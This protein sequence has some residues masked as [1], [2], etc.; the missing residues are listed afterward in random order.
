MPRPD[1]Q[2]DVA[3]QRLTDL[4]FGRA[5]WVPD[6]TGI[7]PAPPLPADV[8]APPPRR[9]DLA[10][11]LRELDLTSSRGALL[12]LA[13]FCA[14]LLLVTAWALMRPHG[15]PAQAAAA[16][17]PVAALPAPT[18][19]GIVVDVAGRVRRPG[20]VTLPAG[21]RVSDAVRAAGG[22]LRPRDLALVN[23]AARVSDGQLLVV[24][25]TDPAAAADGSAGPSA[26]VSLNTATVDQLDGLPGIGPVLAQRIV[27]WRTQHGGFRS[28]RDLDQVS[29][30]GDSIYAELE[31]LVTV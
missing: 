19:S 13:A 27:D 8:S 16:P 3:R 20:L 31:P 5:G 4:G 6:Q 24:G 26:P 22:A 14:V 11:R 9:D 25:V 17:L 28:V 10:S 1:E 18:P 23:L 21:S 15:A 30:I 12:G 7:F 29:G 2:D